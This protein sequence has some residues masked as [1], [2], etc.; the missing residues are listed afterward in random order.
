MA[1]SPQPPRTPVVAVATV[2]YGSGDVLE[3]FLE[4]VPAASADPVTVVVADNGT[5]DTTVARLATA[6]SRNPDHSGTSTGVR[7]PAAR[8]C[9]PS[10]SN[11]KLMAIRSLQ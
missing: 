4:S 11:S 9:A 10:N 1:L 3:G 5:N 7:W 2:S 6:C 8:G